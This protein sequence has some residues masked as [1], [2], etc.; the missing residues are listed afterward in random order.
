MTMTASQHMF[1]LHHSATRSGKS[2]KS[3]IL[4]LSCDQTS[5]T[6]VQMPTVRLKIAVRSFWICFA[7]FC[8]CY[9]GRFVVMQ[10]FHYTF[11]AF[12]QII[13]QLWCS[14]LIIDSALLFI[15]AVFS[16]VLI[17]DF[18][19]V[20]SDVTHHE[21][22]VMFTFN[23]HCCTQ[24]YSALLKLVFFCFRM[25]QLCKQIRYV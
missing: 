17:V 19:Q 14:D 20:E 7:N 18:V 22:G 1:L 4:C 8:C 9:N 13:W 10:N 25:L 11:N 2:A 15:A 12:Q 16:P 3:Q 23:H 21:T 5:S 6:Y 24:T